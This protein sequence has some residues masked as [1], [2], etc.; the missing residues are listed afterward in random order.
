[1]QRCSKKSLSKN[2]WF[3]TSIT[4]ELQRML[5]FSTENLYVIL[6]ATDFIDSVWSS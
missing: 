3:A 5:R 2:N 6:Q 1:M 4:A